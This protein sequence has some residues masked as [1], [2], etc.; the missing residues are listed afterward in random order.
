MA[1][2]FTAVL[3][4]GVIFQNDISMDMQANGRYSAKIHLGKLS[5]EI[6]IDYGLCQV[7]SPHKGGVGPCQLLASS[8]VNLT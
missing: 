6:M 5:P 7:F 2:Y 3:I 8:I 1:A 4:M